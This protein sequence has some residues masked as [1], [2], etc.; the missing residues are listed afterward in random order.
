[1]NIRNKFDLSDPN[2]WPLENEAVVWWDNDKQTSAA[3]IGSMEHDGPSD[4]PT[5]WVVCAADSDIKY[6]AK[7]NCWH[8]TK[9][10]LNDRT[11]THWSPL[12]VRR[13]SVGHK[14]LKGKI[15][16]EEHRDE[17]EAWAARESK[18]PTDRQSDG[19]YVSRY[20][21]HTWA[22]FKFACQLLSEADESEVV[23]LL[24][25]IFGKAV[26]LDDPEE[27]MPAPKEY[28][29]MCDEQI[30][31]MQARCKRLDA[32]IEKAEAIRHVV[33]AY[34]AK[35]VTK[36][37]AEGEMGTKKHKHYARMLAADQCHHEGEAFE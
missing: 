18:Q 32:V 21:H 1:M 11:P 13:S 33:K 31:D 8:I 24:E 25:T 10:E 22:G 28:E 2:T 5:W 34:E 12:P 3:W 37:L 4:D 20:V 7:E 16:P 35:A 19:L 6:N 26:P 29:A 23:K 17:F 9:T 14:P 15:D 36:S 30:A 27:N